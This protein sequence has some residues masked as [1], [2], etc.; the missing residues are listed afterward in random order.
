MV[1]SPFNASTAFNPIL[2]SIAPGHLTDLVHQI[3]GGNAASLSRL[4]HLTVRQLSSIAHSILPSSRD[5]EEIVCDTFLYVWQHSSHFDPARG[6]VLAWLTIIVRNR[7]I[8]LLRRRRNHYSLD[9]DHVRPQVA[10]IA[11][12]RKGPEQIAEEGQASQI[13]RCALAE[14]P[15]LRRQLLELAFFEELTHEEIATALGLPAG[16][17][18]SHIRRALCKMRLDWRLRLKIAGAITQLQ[19]NG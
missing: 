5:C 1:A 2:R 14:L 4:H 3:T 7:S 9:D 19:H 17:V 8:D 12:G 6:S 15:L 18:K 13:I 16:T 10:V 11:C